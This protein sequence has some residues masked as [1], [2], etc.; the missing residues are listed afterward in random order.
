MFR[1]DRFL[2]TIRFAC[3]THWLYLR[4]ELQRW[5]RFRLDIIFHHP[6]GL[7]AQTPVVARGRRGTLS[8]NG[9]DGDEREVGDFAADEV[10]EAGIPF[11]AL[12]A[13]QGSTIQFQVKVFEKG[14][15][16]ECYPETKPIEVTVPGPESALAQWVV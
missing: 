15:E 3:D 5:G 16:R 9:R 10:V 8:L 6:P 7:V 12:G 2:R 4:F 14:I 13:H 11:S 1:D